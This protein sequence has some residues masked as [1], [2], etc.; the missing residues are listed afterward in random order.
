MY[1]EAYDPGVA[2]DTLDE[3]IA[4]IEASF[5]GDCGEFW[6][7]A[8]PVV[9]AEGRIVSAVM[10]VRQAPWDDTPDGPFIIELFTARDYRRRG[11]ARLVIRHC[12]NTIRQAGETTVA[13]RVAH[14][15]T[16]GVTVMCARGLALM[17]LL[18]AQNAEADT[19]RKT[20][21]D[22]SIVNLL[23]RW[24]SPGTPPSPDTKSRLP[25]RRRRAITNQRPEQQTR[26]AN[27]HSAEF[28]RTLNN[29]QYHPSPHVS[30]IGTSEC[31]AAGQRNSFSLLD[32][33]DEPPEPLL[34]RAEHPLGQPTAPTK[35]YVPGGTY[36]RREHQLVPQIDQL[37][38]VDEV[39]DVVGLFPR[40]RPA[41]R[42]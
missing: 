39:A 14:D 2:C 28:P 11:L 30:S 23:S 38:D 40:L 9:E 29:E 21:S 10:T 7:Q 31:S 3:A 4:D 16:P 24:A 18:S 6:Y 8:S 36:V 1:F 27:T 41:R 22:I 32:V 13:P 42:R 25:E 19:I 17:K 15:N 34:E 12:L 33:S 5:Q 37:V 35:P 26:E 20:A